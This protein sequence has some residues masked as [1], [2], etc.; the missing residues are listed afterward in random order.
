MSEPDDTTVS[1]ATA[2]YP[3][4]DITPEEFEAFVTELLNAAGPAADKLTITLHETVTG[5]DGTYDFDATV[6]F[7]LAGM[8]FLVLVEAKRHKHSIKRELVQ[9]LYQKVQSVGAHKGAMISTAPYQSGAVEFAKVHGIALATVT[10]GRYT[11][12]TKANGQAPTMSRKE[13]LERYGLPTFVGHSYGPGAEPG[14]TAVVLLSPE[15]PE[16]IA[17]QILGIPL[18]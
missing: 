11:F 9:I 2:H 15:Y 18:T 6:R 1:R 10:E 16:Y 3:P 5:V 8:A 13:A 4:A 7:E 17:E 14:S 12:E